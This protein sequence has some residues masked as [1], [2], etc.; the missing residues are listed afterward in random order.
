MIWPDFILFASEATE[1]GLWAGGFLLLAV[2]ALAADWRR[3]RRK[4]VDRVGCMPWTPLFL[5]FATIGSG[6]MLVAIKGW[7]GG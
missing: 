4:Q 7:L 6:L 1:L 2:I 3:A 5:A